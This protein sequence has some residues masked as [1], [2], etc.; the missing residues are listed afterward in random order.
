MSVCRFPTNKEEIH[1]QLCPDFKSSIEIGSPAPTG[2]AYDLS[3][4]KAVID[5]GSTKPLILNFGSYT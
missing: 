4:N 2:E 3:G 5:L 1:Y